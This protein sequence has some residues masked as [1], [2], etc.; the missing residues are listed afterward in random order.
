MRMNC[1]FKAFNVHMFKWHLFFCAVMGRINYSTDGTILITGDGELF[2]NCHF[3][4]LNSSLCI[5]LSGLFIH[6][7][8]RMN[9]CFKTFN[10]R[11]CISSSKLEH[12]SN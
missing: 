12:T 7:Y 10:M 3:L 5:E 4:L 6:M 2:E 11:A 8:I 9:C 1:W